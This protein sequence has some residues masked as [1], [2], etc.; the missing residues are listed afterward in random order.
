MSHAR[1]ESKPNPTP[2]DEMR[3]PPWLFE[4]LSEKQGGFNVDIATN[5][6]NSLCKEFYW[7]NE[8]NPLGFLNPDV[9]LVK[10][11]NAYGNPPYS[12]GKIA[13][14]ISK[15]RYEASANGATITMLLPVD[16]S[17]NWWD[18]MMLANEWWRIP[19]R[20]HFYGIDGKP[21]KGSPW[22][23]SIIAV[24]KPVHL[25]YQPYVR[26]LEIPEDVMQSIRKRRKKHE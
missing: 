19:F 8:A 12:K 1:D 18:W 10:G 17:T 4:L 24:F 21:M 14:F 9:H 15:A 26:T 22:F 5:K 13:P 16:F 2:K 25:A 6:T 20:V 23:D 11:D 3:T 7:C